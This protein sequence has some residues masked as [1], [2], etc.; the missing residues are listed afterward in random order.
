MR[1]DQLAK[2]THRRGFLVALAALAVPATVGAQQWRCSPPGGGCSLLIPCCGDE[3]CYQQ[4]LL[5]PNSGIC[6][7]VTEV[8]DDAGPAFI[9]PTTGGT[10]EPTASDGDLTEAQ[11]VARYDRN[12]SGDIDCP[13]F[14]CQEDAQALHDAY[15]GN[16][17]RLDGNS[18]GEVCECNRRCRS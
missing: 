1:F 4:S 15:P 9:S 11:L 14:D 13:D 6:A 17:W 16:T 5:N 8:D 10:T 2:Q 18:D 3:V 12:G 7:G